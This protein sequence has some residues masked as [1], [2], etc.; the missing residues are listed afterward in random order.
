[1]S[2]RENQYALTLCNV[3]DSEGKALENEAADSRPRAPSRP[4]RPHL[5]IFGNDLKR[6]RDF[7]Q[8]D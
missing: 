3:S 7:T 5:R 1:V 4:N 8:K 2:H 6:A